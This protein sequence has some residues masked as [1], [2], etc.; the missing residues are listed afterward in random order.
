MRPFLLTSVLSAL[1]LVAV[2]VSS[3]PATAAK[4]KMGCEKGKERWDAAAGKCVAG[5]SKY[6]GKSAAKK[7]AAKKPAKKS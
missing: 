6:S 7:P 5:K 4:S 3:G 2:A 1:A